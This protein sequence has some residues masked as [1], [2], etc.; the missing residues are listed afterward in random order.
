M[1]PPLDSSHTV[2]GV[3]K[4][5]SVRSAL[6]G[7]LGAQEYP[8]AAWAQNADRWIG[9]HLQEILAACDENVRRSRGR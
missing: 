1:S 5:D 8:E 3:Q 9:V 7:C 6:L 2:V 4:A